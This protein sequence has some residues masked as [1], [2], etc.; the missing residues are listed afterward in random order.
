[1]ETTLFSFFRRLYCDLDRKDCRAFWSEGLVGVF[2]LNKLIG[3]GSAWEELISHL[4]FNMSHSF[5]DRDS[6]ATRV[7]AERALAGIFSVASGNMIGGGGRNF[8]C[9]PSCLLRCTLVPEDLFQQSRK[10]SI[11]FVESVSSTLTAGRAL[12]LLDVVP[13][14]DG[15]ACTSQ[16]LARRPSGSSGSVLLRLRSMA[17]AM[18]WRCDQRSLTLA[19]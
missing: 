4:L 6:G 1:M 13:A 10:L 9:C 15:V 17:I 19:V 14:R 5:Q 2:L 3:D 8:M 11:S 16:A 12:V 18:S 7:G